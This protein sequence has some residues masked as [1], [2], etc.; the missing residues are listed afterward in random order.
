MYNAKKMSL[1]L[2][3]S[4][5]IFALTALLVTNHVMATDLATSPLQTSTSTLVKPNIMFILDNSGSMKW[6]Y[7]PDW[8]SA[9]GNYTNSGGDPLVRNSGYNGV[10]YDPATTYTPPQNAD[11]SYKTSMSSANTVGYTVVPYDGYGIQKKRRIS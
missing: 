1:R 8:V 9:S 6:D 3:L 5:G 2:Q 11:K 7:M 10:Y 4:A